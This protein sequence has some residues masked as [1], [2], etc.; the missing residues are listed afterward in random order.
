MLAPFHAIWDAL[1][2]PMLR[3]PK[4]LQMAALCHRESGERREYLLVTSRGTGRWVIPKGWPIR[5]LRAN[6]TA[7]QEAWEEGGVRGVVETSDPVGTYTYGKRQPNGVVVPVE[8][9]VYSVAVDDVQDRFPEA[10]E[11]TR[12]WV[13]AEEAAELVNEDE[14]K[15]LFH[16]Q[17][18]RRLVS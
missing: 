18:I 13:P 5:G 7:L 6:E 8:T 3:R 2:G 16:A 11:R 4:R 17:K 14:L 1:L 15:H 10:E 9:L 12:L